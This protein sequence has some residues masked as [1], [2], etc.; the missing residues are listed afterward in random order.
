M[1]TFVDLSWYFARFTDPW[2]E[3][4]PTTPDVANRLMPVDQYIGGVEHA[5]LHLLY[6]R[7]FTRAMKATG[8]IDI[9]E[10]FA[11]M[12]TQGMVVHETYRKA[13]GTYVTPAEVRVESAGADRRA[14]LL[15]SGDR[16]RSARSKKCRSR[17]RTRSTPTT[18]SRPTAPT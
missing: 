8:H 7:F 6:S 18:S 9:E 16:L 2:N 3:N 15:S 10:P 14:A 1:D 12:F 11:G 13:D 5:I 4:S 17:R